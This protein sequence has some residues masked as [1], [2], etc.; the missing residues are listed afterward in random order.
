MSVGQGLRSTSG[1]RPAYLR[2][3]VP[4][5]IG[6]IPRTG[7]PWRPYVYRGTGED[8]LTP[9]LDAMPDD[10]GRTWPKGMDRYLLAGVDH[11]SV[12]Q[13]AA[14]LGVNKRTINRYRAL[15][16]ALRGGS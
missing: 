4:T 9:E 7:L 12:A 14:V 6:A 10:G 15:L 1:L 11:L 5:E 8:T 13:A 2:T 16:R 3:T